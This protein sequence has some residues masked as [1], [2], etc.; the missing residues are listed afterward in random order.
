MV[1]LRSKFG[2]ALL[3]IAWMCVMATMAAS[4]ATAQP[5]NCLP[6]CSSVDARFLAIANG[7]G[8]VTLSEP[9]LDLEISV[10]AGTTMFTVGVFDG[11][12]RGVDGSGLSHWDLGATGAIFTYTLYADPQGNRTGTTVVPLS[13]LPTQ[14]STTMPDND[15]ADFTVNTSSIAQAPSGNY[16]YYLRIELTS[17]GLALTNAFK[18]R[19]GG[20]Q[21][22]G[23]TLFPSPKP[24]SYIA[25]YRR[26]CGLPDRLPEF[27]SPRELLDSDDLRRHVQLLLR[28]AG[29]AV[30]VT[31]WDGDFDRGKFD[32]TDKD[33]DD[34]DTPDAPF[35]RPGPLRTRFSEGVAVGAG[36]S[37]GNPP[38]DR[39]SRRTSLNSQAAS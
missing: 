30:E 23:S 15:W 18:V 37:S 38:D 17:L 8:F 31:V 24:F 6:S 20:A 34:P 33:T 10:P 22:G 14:L 12:I 39:Q 7:T 4:P 35:R 26:S 19:T 3:A 21:V 11:D 5:Y 2:M 28:H 1:S 36:T 29:D 9:V 27:P 13:G 25:G 16:F 32:G